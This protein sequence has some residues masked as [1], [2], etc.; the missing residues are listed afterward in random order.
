MIHSFDV[1]LH[2][3]FTRE[4]EAYIEL[5]SMHFTVVTPAASS[6][7][8]V[9]F[10]TMHT[11]LV[12]A[13]SPL[14]KRYQFHKDKATQALLEAPGGQRWMIQLPQCNDV[15]QQLVIFT[16][17]AIGKSAPNRMAFLSLS[18]IYNT[19]ISPNS[20]LCF[21]FPLSGLRR[22]ALGHGGGVGRSQ[23]LG[24]TGLAVLL[25]H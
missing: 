7:A 21:S 14:L 15:L 24:L 5:R 9:A 2:A 18:T 10:P 13:K 4:E 8:S 25:R 12:E 3:E 11:I 23:I 22:G 19:I 20:S 1:E 16:W 6:R 17:P